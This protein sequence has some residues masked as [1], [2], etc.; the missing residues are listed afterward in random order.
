[1]KGWT[2]LNSLDMIAMTGGPKKDNICKNLFDS[3]SISKEVPGLKCMVFV[4]Y[5]KD[6]F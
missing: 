6:T 2:N 3:N 1:M 5:I 4:K